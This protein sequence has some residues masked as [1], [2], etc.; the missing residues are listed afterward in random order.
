MAAATWHLDE[1][2]LRL[3]QETGLLP[4]EGVF[5]GPVTGILDS[6]P[7]IPVPVSADTPA[8]A[9]VAEAAPAAAAAPSSPADAP[10]A[11]DTAARGAAAAPAA[12]GRP[13]SGGSGAA[14]GV[15]DIED[16]APF[17]RAFA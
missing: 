14:A 17:A 7:P 11:L 5:W 8:V 6:T 3:L 15:P 13:G 16:G 2:R 12:S 10:P 4:Q 9:G 1:A